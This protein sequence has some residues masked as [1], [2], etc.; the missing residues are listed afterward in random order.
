MNKYIPRSARP[1]IKELLPAFFIEKDVSLDAETSLLVQTIKERLL[2]LNE[3]LK[4][5]EA[6][7]KI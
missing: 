4:K 6:I 3:R 5:V 7:L 1:F 2:N